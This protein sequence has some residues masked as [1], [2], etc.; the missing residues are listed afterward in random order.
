MINNTEWVSPILRCLKFNRPNILFFPTPTMAWAIC[1]FLV[2]KI[3]STI[4]STFLGAAGSGKMEDRLSPTIF[5]YSG[6]IFR[7]DLFAK[8][9]LNERSITKDGRGKACNNFPREL[10]CCSFRSKVPEIVT[11]F[12]NNADNSIVSVCCPGITDG[13]LVSCSSSNMGSSFS[14]IL[15]PQDIIINRIFLPQN[16]QL[17]GVAI[18]AFPHAFWITAQQIHFLQKSW[19]TIAPV[20]TFDMLCSHSHFDSYRSDI[21]RSVTP[22]SQDRYRHESPL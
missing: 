22:A 2:R 5:L 3:L 12:E 1:G 11:V 14:S 20:H 6:L 17:R 19:D 15:I 16:E 21:Q 18:S 13:D 10:A 9:I 8:P 7:H 4:D